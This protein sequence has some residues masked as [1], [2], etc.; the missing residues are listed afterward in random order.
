MTLG[1]TVVSAEEIGQPD[2]ETGIIIARGHPVAT[3]GQ[4][5]LRGDVMTY[6]PATRQ[7]TAEGHVV[8]H[9]MVQVL[10]ATR[11][12]YNFQTREGVAENADGVF[13]NYYLKADKINLF[14]GP[15]YQALHATWTTCDRP[16]PH[17]Q[18]LART[19][20]IVPNDYWVAHH[21]GIDLLGVRL[22]TVPRLRRDLSKDSDQESLYPSFGYENHYGLF[23]AKTFTLRDAAPVWL[24]AHLRVNTSHDP[25]AGLLAATAGRLQWVGALYYRDRAENQRIRQLEVS[26]LPEIGLL[27]TPNEQAQPGR[28]LPGQIANVG[29]PRYYDLSRKWL[30]SGEITGGYF[31]QYQGSDTNLPNSRSKDGARLR[32]EGVGVL[33]TVKLGPIEL[34]NLKL[35]ARG[36]TYDTGEVFG[37]FGTGIGKRFRLGHWLF[38]IN[39]F[40]QFRAG[41]TPFL[42]DSVELTQEWRPRLQYTSRGFNFTYYTRIRGR[43]GSVY[44]HVVSVSKLLHCLEPRITYQFRR[45]AVL[46][47][48]RIPGISGFGRNPASESQ[49]IETNEFRDDTLP[50]P[51]LP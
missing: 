16:S 13:R 5:E 21:V 15:V 8:I 46:F 12:T 28:F 10:N 49:T 11:A 50:D 43:S 26:R 17:Y 39:R 7:F 51:S 41:E 48:L 24:K 38:E 1:G 37:A 3:R 33:P 6:D 44:D 27:W 42:F 20:D 9:R 25:S 2:S 4:D 22:A 40:D 36:S 47:E 23:A 32:M 35:M 14:E 18:V 31:R 34:N 19:M 30:F 45:Q 29:V